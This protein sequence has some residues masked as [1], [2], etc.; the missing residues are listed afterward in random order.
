MKLFG[1]K[2]ILRKITK[3]VATGF[4]ILMLKCMKFEFGWGNT[5]N[6][7]GELTG[8]PNPAG[9]KGAYF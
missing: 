2:L 6:A 4:H 3:T 9:F 1:P 5:P 7:L 8:L